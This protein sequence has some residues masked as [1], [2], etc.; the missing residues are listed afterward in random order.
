MGVATYKLLVDWNNDGDFTDTYDDIT[1]NV[2]SI[3]CSRGREK[4]ITL[5]GVGL[6]GA[7][8]LTATLNNAS[9]KFSAGN[10]SSPIYGSIKPGR[11]VRLIA[12]VSAVDYTLWTG[13]L[14]KIEP[15]IDTVGAVATAQLSALGAISRL[16]DKDVAPPASNSG[17]LTG[18]LV[19]SVLDEAGIDSADYSVEAGKTTTSRWY[20]A[21]GTNALDA[22]RD[23]EDTEIGFLHEN[24]AGQI[25]FHDRHHR[26][27]TAASTTS[28]GTFSDANGASLG[29]AEIGQVDTQEQIV[30]EV[31]V[32]VPA[33]TVAAVGV[34]WTL[35]ETGVEIGPGQT[36]QFIAEYPNAGNSQGAYV[37]SWQTPVPGTDILSSNVDAATYLEVGTIF[38]STTAIRFKTPNKMRI[39]I[40]NTH[41]VNTAVL[42]LVQAQG[43]AVTYSDA[44]TVLSEDAT[45]K[46]A[47]GR[48]SY[49]FTGP[50]LPNTTVAQTYADYLI[51]QYKNPVAALALTFS[52]SRDSTHM[53]QAI[54][55]ALSDR[56][57]VT[58][59]NRS[60][61]GLTAT[62]WIIERIEHRLDALGADHKVALTVTPAS[63]ATFW[64]LGT[65]ALDTGTVLAF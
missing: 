50:W 18:S 12:T 28:Q 10:A 24:A 63:A 59:A 48:R 15:S 1:G 6:A 37:S 34:L 41:P 14:D 35:T 40:R 4:P 44:I 9:G 60:K 43:T 45:S 25:V 47:H 46:T 3:A 2:Q 54:G 23:L 33:F 61:L 65:S 17:A 58:A 7:G 5:P 64:I 13:Y 32:S 21:P 39:S 62:D 22:I 52:A 51:A 49:D 57:T 55:R 53:A 8:Q 56:I 38:A 26:L 11:K 16:V 42:T 20:V 31:T 29:I 36:R 19:T 27:T 30:N